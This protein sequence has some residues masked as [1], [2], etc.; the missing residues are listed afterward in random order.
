[1]NNLDENKYSK[2][3]KHKQRTH[4]LYKPLP[5]T[6][7]CSKEVTYLVGLVLVYRVEDILNNNHFIVFVCV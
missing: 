1:M 7:L 3:K 5:S 2:E 6:T 4:S